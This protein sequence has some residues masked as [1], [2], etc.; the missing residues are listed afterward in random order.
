MPMK[1]VFSLVDFGLVSQHEVVF[2]VTTMVMGHHGLSIQLITITGF[3][4]SYIYNLECVLITTTNTST[5]SSTN[6]TRF[7]K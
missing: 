5:N 2:A 4:L 7:N 1:H 3:F 6:D